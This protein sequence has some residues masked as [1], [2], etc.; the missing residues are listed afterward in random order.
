[1]I[2]GKG[3]V[4]PETGATLYNAF[5]AHDA[6]QGAGTAT[7]PVAFTP[8]SGRERSGEAP[9]LRR[10]PNGAR[11]AD[12]ALINRA[13]LDWFTGAGV[14]NVDIEA[15]LAKLTAG[16]RTLRPAQLRQLGL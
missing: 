9:W 8:S 10:F 14:I 1:L 2:P 4:S 13:S 7:R 3:V 11:E 6:E 12:P 15:E 16:W 5:R